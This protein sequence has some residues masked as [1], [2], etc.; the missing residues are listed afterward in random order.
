MKPNNLLIGALALLLLS[1]CGQSDNTTEPGET[2]LSAGIDKATE[3]YG[4]SVVVGPSYESDECPLPEKFKGYTAT[5][6]CKEHGYT[7]DG[8]GGIT[9]QCMLA[10]KKKGDTPTLYITAYER[11]FHCARTKV[12][13]DGCSAATCADLN[14]QFSAG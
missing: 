7:E 14:K 12:N 13:P 5:S 4:G 3:G 8:L 10:A 1:A 2:S 11:L 9:G 6:W